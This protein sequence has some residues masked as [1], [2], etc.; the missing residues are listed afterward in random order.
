MSLTNLLL[1]PFY[2]VTYVDERGCGE[3]GKLTFIGERKLNEKSNI[4]HILIE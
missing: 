2:N 1:N 4:M 3:G